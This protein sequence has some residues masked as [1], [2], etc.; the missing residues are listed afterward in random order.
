MRKL[1][2]ATAAVAVGLIS[3]SPGVASAHGR[4]QAPGPSDLTLADVLLADSAGDDAEGF[5][6]DWH[7]YDIV[8]QAVLLF[9][10]L[11]AAASNP[12]A[13]LTVFLPTD[14]AFRKL[15]KD[16]TGAPP[17]TEAETFAAVA[18]LGVDTVES[19]LLYHIVPARIS[20]RDA[21][22]SNGATIPT[23]LDGST[24][25]VT[26]RG[27]A[28]FGTVRLVDADTDD[29]DARVRQPNI[30]GELANGYGHGID[31]VLRPIDLP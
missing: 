24:L 15:V 21:L 1:L 10:D 30:G 29:R 19:V 4:A 8:T 6:H 13:D 5:D 16:V 7:D 17:K 3:L 2:T 31:R 9:P 14:R 26:A 23:L 22:A 20:Y 28:W 12:D 25:G 18:S 11:V 27:T